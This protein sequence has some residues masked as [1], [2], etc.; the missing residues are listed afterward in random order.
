MYIVY[1]GL[2]NPRLSVLSI[3]LEREPGCSVI[4]CH[5]SMLAMNSSTLSLQQIQHFKIKRISSM[6][7]F[8]IVQIMTKM[9]MVKWQ[10]PLRTALK[11][12]W[13]F[14]KKQNVIIISVKI[15]VQLQVRLSNLKQFVAGILCF[16]RLLKDGDAVCH[17]GRYWGTSSNLWL[18]LAV[19]CFKDL[20]LG[21]TYVGLCHLIYHISRAKLFCQHIINKVSK[22]QTVVDTSLFWYNSFTHD[23]ILASLESWMWLQRI[24]AVAVMCPIANFAPQVVSSSCSISANPLT[25]PQ[26]KRVLTSKVL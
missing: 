20:M 16:F 7:F 26:F 6:P 18:D 5:L 12:W 25:R 4:L 3:L 2:L 15:S 10:M 14:L 22:H 8:V 19:F 21:N 11:P 9:W 13:H 24:C 1:V 17:K 23:L